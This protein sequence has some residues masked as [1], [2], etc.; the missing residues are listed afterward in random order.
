MPRVS[1]GMPVYNGANFLGQALESLLAQT[2]TD[3]ELIISDNASSDAT[4]EICRAFAGTDSRIRYTRT[5]RTIGPA[6]NHN[7]LVRMARGDYFRWA[8]HDDLC[9]PEL[10]A[11]EVEVLDR[12]RS[13]VLVYPKTRI[14][15]A[16]G[17]T[18]EDYEQQL[19]RLRH[20]TFEV[21]LRK[22]RFD[23]LRYRRN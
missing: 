3:F 4:A 15:D 7:R 21:A 17:N 9:A 13:V 8:A 20:L 16:T 22:M 1:I 11:K 12:D 19:R 18:V 6:E 14:I 5:E 2:Y 10:L 23:N